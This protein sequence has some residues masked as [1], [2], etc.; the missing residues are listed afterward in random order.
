MKG[1]K[2]RYVSV[3]KQK[4]GELEAV[5][6]LT[7]DVWY[8]WNPLFELFSGDADMDE[9]A[10]AEI[11]QKAIETL[12][13]SCK[14]GAVVFID[15][16]GIAQIS[17]TAVT[18]ILTWLEEAQL[19]PIPVATLSSPENLI[20]AFGEFIA[21]RGRGIGVRIFF[22]EI[23][24]DIAANLNHLSTSLGL[25]VSAS[26]LF[27]DLEHIPENSL[28]MLTVALPPALSSMP[29]LA[30]WDTVT[31]VGT[32]IPAVLE[33]PPAANAV[34]PRPEWLL[35]CG[36][37]NQ[38]VKHVKRLD[39]GDYAIPHPDSGAGYGTGDQSMANGAQPAQT[40]GNPPAWKWV[41]TNGVDTNDHI[42]LV[43]N[44]VASTA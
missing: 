24:R 31:L 41:G 4:A 40:G 9:S 3:L 42:T 7:S 10:R 30:Q 2:N 39:F 33:M 28:S 21:T 32:G 22:D 35:W 20:A 11:K 37:K 13:E 43:A 36:V 26:H 19:I 8:K 25:D 27:I 5:R 38:I 12:V 15:F 14:K 1:Q 18:E 23:D 29:E 16:D 44:Q 34:L 17:K 6:E